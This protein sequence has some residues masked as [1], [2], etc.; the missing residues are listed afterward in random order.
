MGDMWRDSVGPI[1][2]P[3]HTPETRFCSKNSIPNSSPSTLP[4]FRF[5]LK[6]DSQNIV[7][8][9]RKLHV[10]WPANDT[11]PQAKKPTPTKVLRFATVP[12]HKSVKR[13]KSDESLKISL[14]PSLFDARKKLKRSLRSCLAK[15]RRDL[16]RR[17]NAYYKRVRFSPPVIHGGAR[18][19]GSQIDCISPKVRAIRSPMNLNRHK[20][21]IKKETHPRQN[22]NIAHHSPLY[23]KSTHSCPILTTSFTLQSDVNRSATTGFS[24][25]K[26]TPTNRSPPATPSQ[27]PKVLSW[28]EVGMQLEQERARARSPSEEGSSR[29]SWVGGREEWLFK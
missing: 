21:R 6:T 25:S 23:K 10:L 7:E 20:K 13:G 29:R 9:L 2:E 19:L 4:S 3:F 12:V 28:E 22:R 8:K 1:S 27:T 18:S 14:T 15:P 16:A 11:K 26:V 17:K 24:A 5:E